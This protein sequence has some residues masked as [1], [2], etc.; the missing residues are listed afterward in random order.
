MLQPKSNLTV[1]EGVQMKNEKEIKRK[2]YF[3]NMC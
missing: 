2:N 1:V 3:A